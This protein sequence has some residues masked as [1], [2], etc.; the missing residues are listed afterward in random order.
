MLNLCLCVMQCLGSYRWLLSVAA[1]KHWRCDGY[2][3]DCWYK[4]TMQVLWSKWCLWS[5]NWT[6]FG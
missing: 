3:W 4:W 5:R 2:C 6:V 1:R